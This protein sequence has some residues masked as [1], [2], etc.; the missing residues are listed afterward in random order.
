[1]TG[2]HDIWAVLP[3]KSMGVAKSRL[4][5]CCPPSFRRE[6]ARAM[7]ADVLGA[8]TATAAIAGIVV[9]TIDAVASTLA[10]R[11][12]ARVFADDAD[13]GHTGAVMGA[14]R[15]LAREHRAGMLALPSDIPC[16]DAAELSRLVEIH[17]DAPA[18]TIV[19]SHDGRGSNA[20]VVSKP[21]AVPLAFGDDSFVAH[22]A[23]ARREGI[24][25]VIAA[26]PGIALDIDHPADLMRLMQ[27]KARTNTAEFLR[28]HANEGVV[29]LPDQRIHR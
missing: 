16:V 20:I 25:P 27:S 24:E 29:A 23:A 13:I 2:K 5:H 28:A 17:G 18:F 14:A 22:L 15:R 4:A 10:R 19:P 8:L 11:C 6:L 21:T 3:V 26:M 1:M 9:V 7:L 12:G